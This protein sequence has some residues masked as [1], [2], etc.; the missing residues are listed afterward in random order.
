M[1][2]RGIAL[3][4]A[5]SLLWGVPYLFIRIAVEQMPPAVL[6]FGRTTLAAL[7][8]LPL[9]L[10]GRGLLPL[11]RR[12]QPLLAFA[13]IEIALPWYFI[14]N[15][16]QTVSSSLAGLLLSAVPL[17]ATLIAIGR[18]DR[19]GIRPVALAGL[20]LGSAGVAAIVGL[21]I[22][23]SSLPAILEL[24][25][26]AVC[27]AIGP[28][29]LARSLRDVPQTG[30]MASSLT[31]C[32]IAYLPLALLQWPHAAPSAGALGS[33]VVLSVFCTA[34]AFLAFSALIAEIGPVRSTVITYVNPAVAAILGVLVLHETFTLGMGVGFLLVLVGSVLATR[35]V[36]P[37]HTAVA[38]AH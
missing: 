11:L 22:R 14:S 33:I 19:E 25:A 21:D 32:A 2:R 28:V 18:G 12:W 1:S 35:R 4:A 26:T 29:I 27:Y 31:L 5:M 13:A 6:V 9:A 34:V 24:L 17:A 16:E 36:Q 38:E 30:V 15:A 37:R 23:G 3:F 10:R 8:L 20:A 7:I